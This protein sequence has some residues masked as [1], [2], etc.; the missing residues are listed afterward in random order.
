MTTYLVIGIVGLVL[1]GASLL[2][3]DLLDSALDFLAGDAFSTAVVG[4]FVSAFGFGTA[5][6]QAAGLPTLGALGVGVVAGGLMG[7]FAAW[8][9]RLVRSGGSDATPET[10]D[11]VGREATVLTTIPSEG[12]GTVRVQ[13]GGHV[14]RLNARA[15]T[16]IPGGTAVHVTGVLSPSA[17]TV[18]PTYDVLG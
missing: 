14:V 15:E 16:E 9:T 4:G 8:L 7:W 18:S 3:G 11:A 13:M 1:L 5:L 10:A 2:L 6:A 12:Y 17:V